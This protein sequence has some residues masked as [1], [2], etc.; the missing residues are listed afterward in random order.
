MARADDD[1]LGDLAGQISRMKEHGKP[2]W[3]SNVGRPALKPSLSRPPLPKPELSSVLDVIARAAEL[4]HSHQD[5]AGR[6]ETRATEAEK[7]LEHAVRQIAELE[8]RLR[9]AS[10]EADRE[11]A[12][13]D[14]LK[15]R[16]AELIE[17]TQG[18][19]NE[20]SER[21]LAAEWRA[22]QAEENFSTLRDAVE[23]QFGTRR[24]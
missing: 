11:R 4:M 3:A 7:R 18:M 22:D 10:D 16:S 21:L 13:A 23:Q 24:A 20:A 8:N 19:L 2:L 5:Q 1:R 15:T 14:D 9:A 17:K 12:R 6:T